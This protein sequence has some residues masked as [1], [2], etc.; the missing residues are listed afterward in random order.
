MSETKLIIE[1]LEAADFDTEQPYAYLWSLKDTPFKQDQAF[2]KMQ[3]KAKELKYA[4]FLRSWQAYRKQEEKT[5]LMPT[6]EITDFTDM[7]YP[8]LSSGRW[9]CTNEGV[10]T[11]VPERGDVIACPHPILI[12]DRFEDVE[13]GTVKVKL[14]FKLGHSWRD[15]IIERSVI[16]SSQKIIQLAD[17]GIG[18]TSESAKFL[19]QYLA[20]LEAIN[21]TTIPTRRSVS[22]L[23]WIGDGVFS[24]YQ[25]DITFDGQAA[26]RQMYEAVQSKG[27][28]EKWRDCI[29]NCLKMDS[30]VR[31]VTAAA[32]ASPLLAPLGILSSIV[33]LYATTSTGKTMIMKMAV[34]GWGDPKALIKSF[35]AT[36]YA[37]EQYASF[38][39]GVPLFVDELQINREKHGGSKKVSVYQM[40]QGSSGG[41][42]RRDGGLRDERQWRLCYVT[43]GEEP[44]ANTFDASGTNARMIEV[45]LDREIVNMKTGHSVSAVIDNNYGHAAKKY[46]ETITGI[47]VDGLMQRYN[48]ISEDL[49]KFGVQQKQLMSAS[50]LLLAYE[51]LNGSVFMGK[52]PPLTIEEL[53]PHLLMADD[54]DPS[55]GA[56]EQLIEWVASNEN[57]FTNNTN[58]ERLGDIDDDRVYIIKSCFNKFIESINLSP[59]SVLIGLAKR[60]LIDTVIDGEKTRFDIQRRINGL[61]VRVVG[62][63]L[64]NYE[65]PKRGGTSSWQG[66]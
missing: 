36:P 46:I 55:I 39:N 38:C 59:R 17:L 26:F 27:K 41:R 8:V 16:A 10:Y 1:S 40:T 23:G 7:P 66:F 35:N 25:D 19:V 53:L 34:S 4:G 28:L 52:A 22:R 30:S 5:M 9:I 32:F 58:L 33:H 6:G 20:D 42:G 11:V 12:T 63:K 51:I 61:K 37:M 56:Y 29:V 18:V 62:T 54:I 50:A 45:Y 60:G 44:I 43:S 21:Y 64:Q 49:G 65:K 24:P 57:R 48:E 3:A 2:K 14:A 15:V 13:T 31:I 47:G